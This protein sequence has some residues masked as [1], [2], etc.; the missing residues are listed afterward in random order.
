MLKRVSE[1]YK[2]RILIWSLAKTDFKTK[3]AGSYLG[4]AWAFVQPVTTLILYWLVFEFGMKAAQPVPDVPYVLWLTAGLVPWF[5]FSDALTNSTNALLEYSYLVKKI[6]FR[7]SILPI[8]KIISALFVHAAFLLFMLFIYAAYGM[9][10][11]FY[12]FQLLYY[13]FCVICFA[14]SLSYATAAIIVF[15]RDLGQIISIV[16]QILM[17]ATPIIWSYDIVP[18]GY[19]WIIKLNPLF[20]I[21][22][23][24][25]E[26]LIFGTWF[27]SRPLLT[28]YFWLVTSV[29]FILCSRIFKKLK[30]HFADLL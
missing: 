4:I 6:L 29:L 27:W 8:V 9:F 21:V 24:Y 17:W 15:F 28:A 20:Y 13:S 12:I 3:Y 10:P 7:I 5:F 18:K 30:P 1:L 14:L 11:Y 22:N 23:G 2:S 19:Q 26:T 25:R 16:M